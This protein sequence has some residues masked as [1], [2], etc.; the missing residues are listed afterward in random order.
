MIGKGLNLAHVN[1]CSIF[2]KITLLEQL[3]SDYDFLCC[4]E[5]WLDNRMPDNLAKMKNMNIF[6]SDRKTTVLTL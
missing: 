3:Y 6:R 5:T 2:R 4:T 1:T